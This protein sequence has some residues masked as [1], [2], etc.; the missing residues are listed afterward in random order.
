MVKF[1]LNLVLRGNLQLLWH[2]AASARRWGLASSAFAHPAHFA[3]LSSEQSP[4]TRQ[5]IHACRRAIHSGANHPAMPSNSPPHTGAWCWL[6][7]RGSQQAAEAL[8]KLGRIYWY[9]LYA[10][11]RRQG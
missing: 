5:L 11:V 9:P 6:R 1:I 3:M 4:R 2:N 8:E 7:A 10:Y